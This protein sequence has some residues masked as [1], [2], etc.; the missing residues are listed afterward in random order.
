M[1]IAVVTGVR[2][3]CSGACLEELSKSRTVELAC[4]VFTNNSA[5]K[6]SRRKRLAK[7]LRIGP[8]GALNGLRLRK[9]YG[10]YGA[11]DVRAEAERLGLPFV[12]VNT[13]N[14]EDC[15]NALRNHRIDLAVSLGNGYIGSK[16]FSIPKHGFINYHGELL[17]EYPGAQSIVWPIWHGRTTTGFTIHKIDRDI[18][19][20]EILYRREFPIHFR[21]S[22]RET[23]AATARTIH[24]EMPT[25][26]RHVVENFVELAGNATQELPER[27][28]TTTRFSEYL[29]MVR[30]NRRLWITAGRPRDNDA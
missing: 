7:I 3:G 19:T 26:V 5:V 23:V 16:T 25:A 13:V 8:L 1:K 29:L 6:T 11:R 14:G 30:N 2:N 28:Y 24:S 18:D 20:G 22:L 4:V 27:H 17:P 10:H 12:E 9:W 15:R 21:R